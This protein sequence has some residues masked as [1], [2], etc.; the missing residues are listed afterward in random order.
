MSDPTCGTAGKEKHCGFLTA[1]VCFGVLSALV[2][3]GTS[4]PSPLGLRCQ[5]IGTADK[6]S[7]SFR[8]DRSLEPGPDGICLA[9]LPRLSFVSSEAHKDRR[10][11]AVLG[12]TVAKQLPGQLRVNYFRPP[13]CL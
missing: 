5:H 4:I 11:F 8:P 3:L 10:E 7:H 9:T 2:L 13:P 6:S 12:I 1:L